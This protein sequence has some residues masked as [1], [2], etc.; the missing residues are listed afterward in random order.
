MFN[1]KDVDTNVIYDKHLV[2]E[3]FWGTDAGRESLNRS[4]RFIRARHRIL[5]PSLTE[6]QAP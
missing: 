6:N 1:K 4:L 2:N 3:N 5:I